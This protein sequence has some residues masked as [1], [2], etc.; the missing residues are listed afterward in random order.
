MT[1]FSGDAT[2]EAN[3]IKL[4]RH[5]PALREPASERHYKD[6]RTQR[7]RP[8]DLGIGFALDPPLAAANHRRAG[9]RQL[10]QRRHSSPA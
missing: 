3:D 2:T 6:A 5:D 7:T 9:R 4:L 1:R 10:A 8:S